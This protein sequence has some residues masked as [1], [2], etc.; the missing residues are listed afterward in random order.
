MASSLLPA[1]PE[2]RL[3]GE[4]WRVVRCLQAGGMGAVY[5]VTHRET[6]ARCALKVMLPELVASA[7]MRARFR[8]EAMVTA[9]IES[10]H[11]VKVFDG[12]TD[13]ESGAP[14]LVMELLRG[15]DLSAR[16]AAAGRLDD[17]AA[18]A[19][20]RQ[21]ALALERTH[22]AGVVHRDLKPANLFVTTRDDGSPCLKILDFG[23]AKVIASAS[24]AE[25]TRAVGTPLYM[26]PEQVRGDGTIAAPADLYALAQIAYTL[27]VGR[28]YWKEEQTE[29]KPIYP[30][31]MAITEGAREPAT[32]R[33]MRAG[34]TLKAA[35]D[36]WFVRAVAVAPEDRFGG[37]REMIEALA[38]ALGV[39]AAPVAAR[40]EAVTRPVSVPP[41]ARPPTVGGTARDAVDGGRRSLALTLLGGAAAAAAMGGLAWSLRATRGAPPGSPEPPRGGTITAA[42]PASVAV[43]PTAVAS[44]VTA[45]SAA[46]S[47]SALPSA[48]PSP[49]IAASPSRSP[50]APGSRGRPSASARASVA[51]PPATVSDPSDVYH[52]EKKP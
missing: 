10:D 3:V 1:L 11:I 5:A 2:G 45:P 25:T 37:A 12:G 8:Q 7:E 43:T 22:A 50:S 6:Q 26:A 39:S 48:A 24:R 51:P 20:L 35:F 17:E 41:A 47:A 33:A 30:L 16:L 27:L 21:A 46:A 15:E 18:V 28:P 34:V 52:P 31:L 4:R 42:A 40:P 14:Y 36:A 13:A 38:A 29:G 44:A 19:L 23:I 32:A 9:S 49:P